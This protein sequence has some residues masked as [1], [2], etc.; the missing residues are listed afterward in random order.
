M[1]LKLLDAIRTE[2][3]SGTFD[4]IEVPY[5]LYEDVCPP[6]PKKVCLEAKS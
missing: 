2:M 5:A 4:S 3:D 1:F 6:P